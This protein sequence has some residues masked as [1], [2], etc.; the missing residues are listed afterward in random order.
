MFSSCMLLVAVV[1]FLM[2]RPYCPLCRWRC[3]LM[4]FAILHALSAFCDFPKQPHAS[5]LDWLFLWCSLMN[6]SFLDLRPPAA[7]T[8]CCFLPVRAVSSGGLFKA[9][10]ELE[11]HCCAF[12]L[13]ARWRRL[14]LA[15]LCLA[16]LRR[17]QP[18]TATPE[19]GW[20]VC[21]AGWLSWGLLCLTYSLA[22]WC[23]RWS[24]SSVDETTQVGWSAS[25]R[26]PRSLHCTVGW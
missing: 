21:W 15:C 9:F 7:M 14:L 23:Q 19:A 16:S 4:M 12:L 10:V 18:S 26:E 22:I 17:G 24:A 5:N 8:D 3:G 25:D 11:C 20:T 1:W 2:S 6:T 13:R